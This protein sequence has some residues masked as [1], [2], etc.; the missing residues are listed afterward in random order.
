LKEQEIHLI[1]LLKSILGTDNQT[2]PCKNIRGLINTS[3]QKTKRHLA[4]GESTTDP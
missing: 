4:P 3:G 1:T 2:L